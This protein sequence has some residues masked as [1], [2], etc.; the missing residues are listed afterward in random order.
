MFGKYF[1]QNDKILGYNKTLDKFTKAGIAQI[2]FSDCSVM[3]LELNG[4]SRKQTKKKPG[5]VAKASNPSTL[6][7]RGRWIMRSRDRDHPGQH[8]ETPSLLKLQ[9]KLAR[10][11]GGCL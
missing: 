8:G 5:V 6:G 9:Q 11:G 3:K 7:G 2:R 1:L 10:H 4:K